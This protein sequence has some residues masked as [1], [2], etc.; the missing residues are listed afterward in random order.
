MPLSINLVGIPGGGDMALSISLV[1]IP[2]GG[3]GSKR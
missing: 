2:G 3:G 1:G